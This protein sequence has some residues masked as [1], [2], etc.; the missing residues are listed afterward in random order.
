MKKKPGTFINLFLASC[1]LHN[2][3]QH[4]LNLRIRAKG[5]L[6]D[7]FVADFRQIVQSLHFF[8]CFPSE[9]W[10]H[11]RWPGNSLMVAGSLCRILANIIW[12][13]D[14]WICSL[15]RLTVCVRTCRVAAHTYSCLFLHAFKKG[16]SKA[17]GAL[18][19]QL[20][21]YATLCLAFSL[22]GKW[23]HPV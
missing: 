11:L 22:K 6:K 1:T 21:V 16:Y 8:D 12:H 3:L 13:Q 14:V 2:C 4:L 5:R 15:S 17:S 7:S 19:P 20:H 23:N 10:D 18:K 9:K